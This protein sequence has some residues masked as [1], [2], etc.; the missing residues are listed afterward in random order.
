MRFVLF[1]IKH[2]VEIIPRRKIVLRWTRGQPLL[3]VVT[4]RAGFLRQRRELLDVTFDA[5]FVSGEFQSL[6]FVAICGRNQIARQITLVVTGIALQFMRLK[7]AR[8]FDHAKMR[9]MREAF[10]IRRGLCG[11]CDGG[12]SW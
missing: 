6:L 12:G 11:R 7:R 1:G 8:H 10:V 3:R 2:G 9:L 4:N 5:G